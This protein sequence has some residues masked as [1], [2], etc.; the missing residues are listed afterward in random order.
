RRRLRDGE[1]ENF[2][3]EKRYCR[4]DGSIVWGNVTVSLMRKAD[5][6]PDYYTSVDEDICA[7]RQA[8]EKLRASE[9]RLRLALGA[10]GLGVF[11]WNVPAD[12]AVWEN[13]RMYEM[14]GHTSADGTLSKEHLTA[15]YV[16]P[17]DV[18]TFEQAL[19]D[20][21]KSGRPVHTV[22]RIR[23]K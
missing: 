20:G 15:D 7:R 22:Y 2:S 18:A 8:E 1:I 9:E 16:H 4:K 23:R 3:I 21:M 6:S 12:Y 10:A 13:E 19:A 5:G 17:D 11:E 14:F